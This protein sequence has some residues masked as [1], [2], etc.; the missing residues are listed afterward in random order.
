MKLQETAKANFNSKVLGM[1]NEM[2][3]K[4]QSK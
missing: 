1:V 2:Q 4:N 3:E